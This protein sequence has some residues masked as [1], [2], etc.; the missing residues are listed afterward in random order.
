MLLIENIEMPTRFLKCVSVWQVEQLFNYL[1]LNLTDQLPRPLVKIC[2]S[3]FID[4]ETESKHRSYYLET[5]GLGFMTQL[6]PLFY[7]RDFILK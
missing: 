1:T 2:Y 5:L 3:H 7:I 6:H 4:E